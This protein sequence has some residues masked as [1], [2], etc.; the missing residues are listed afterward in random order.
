[1][2]NAASPIQCQLAHQNRIHSLNDFEVVKSSFQKEPGTKSTSKMFPKHAETRF[3]R[4]QKKT[5]AHV[6]HFVE[7]VGIKSTASLIPRQGDD[8]WSAAADFGFDPDVSLVSF[9]D[10][11]DNGQTEPAAFGFCGA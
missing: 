10:A 11:A 4:I 8:N 3:E 2:D 1:M 9:D 5:T 6:M 7:S